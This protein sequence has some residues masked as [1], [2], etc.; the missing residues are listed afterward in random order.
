[1]RATLY[2][3][4]LLLACLYPL[5]PS[6]AQIQRP[7]G[8]FSPLSGAND[9]GSH[10]K[11]GTEEDGDTK[12]KTDVPVGLYVWQIDTRFGAVRPTEPDT[13]AHGFQN[14]AFNTGRTGRYNDTGNLGS[15]RQSRYFSDAAI[16][17][18]TPQFEFARP[19]DYF[20]TSPEQWHFTN[21]K[22]PFMNITYHECGNKQNGEDRIKAI[23][24]TNAGK[25]LG[26]GFKLDYLYGRGYY[27]SQST[28]HFNGSL[29][30]SYIAPRYQL[31]AIYYANHLKNAENGGIEDD[32]YVNR[33]EI[34]PTRYGTA[35]MPTRL[36]KT[37]NKLNVNTLFITHRYSLGFEA[38]RQ[39]DGRWK[40]TGAQTALLKG[41][42][43][44]DTTSQQ[45]AGNPSVGVKDS[46]KTI[47]ADNVT[48]A[49]S[50]P[51]D[52]IPIEFVPVAG[53]IHTFRLDHDNRRLLSNLDASAD[54]TTFWN[55]F[56]LPGDSVNDYTS[57]LHAQNLVALELREGFNRWAKAGLRLFA[58]HD[59][60]RYTLPDAQR[61]QTAYT[62][63]YF[64]LGAQLLKSQ[65][66][67]F[68][69]HV[70][71]EM[72]TSG[73][74]WGEFN[75][76]ADAD[77]RFKLGRDTMTLALKGQMLNER[78]TFYYRHYHG[79]NAWWDA[80]LDKRFTAR[81]TAEA[82][83]GKTRLAVHLMTQQKP[84]F[85]RMTLTP[86]TIGSEGQT[87]MLRS[88]GVEQSA[89][90]VSAFAAELNRDF[91][92]GPFRWENQLTLQLTTDK[93]LQP[94]P[95]FTAYTNLYLHFKIAGVLTTDLGADA[96]FYTEYEAPDYEPAI[97][98]FALQDSRY[99]VK[100]GNYPIVN[101]YAN[102][103]LKHTRFY[104]MASH[105]NYS[106]GGGNPFV[107]PHYPLNRMVIRFG[108][109]WNFFN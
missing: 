25:R 91:A 92:F 65:G 44:A 45:T 86:A 51:T 49:V 102:F 80:D 107:T 52:S 21:T 70:L 4:L 37:W 64:S 104:L 109:S 95:L 89:G 36:S 30:G 24:A 16:Q 26:L 108:L 46:V 94:L 7:T 98:G 74:D 9:D 14:D 83:Y 33:P 35:D 10:W 6:L 99:A 90:N 5:S 62:E 75:V 54:N 71:G 17:A 27:T 50:D 31:H 84:Y 103:H 106:S 39:P 40:R 100:T 23:F 55:D 76:E 97:G 20:I 79:R 19:Y 69:Y 28:A 53:I 48:A 2:R 12:Q 67:T 87:V 13:V 101:V 93:K 78:P 66:R 96:R 85:Y 63:N 3:I 82:A 47:K 81:V 11:D 41:V 105:V 59:Y 1:M 68:H 88:V 8:G 42:M 18:F 38:R 73:S 56:Y 58:R 34:F 32:D 72:R 77:V 15:P 29:F 43:A 60:Y 57:H 22:S 61:R